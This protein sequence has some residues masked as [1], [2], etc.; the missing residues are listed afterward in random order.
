MIGLKI[1]YC[2]K[3]KAKWIYIPLQLDCSQWDSN[4][5]FHQHFDRVHNIVGIPVCVLILYKDRTIRVSF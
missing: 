1:Y 5:H 2:S 3:W 4:F